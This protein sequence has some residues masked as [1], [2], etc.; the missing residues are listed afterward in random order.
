MGLKRLGNTSDHKSFGIL[1]KA[2]RDIAVTV[3]RQSK[4]DDVIEIDEIALNRQGKK[5]FQRLRSTS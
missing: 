5:A 2:L 1:D 3:N 4:L